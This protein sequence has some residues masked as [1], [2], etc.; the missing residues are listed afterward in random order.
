LNEQAE[1]HLG[2]GLSL[3]HGHLIAS[4][5]ESNMALQKLIGSV[6]GHAPAHEAEAR[7]SVAIKRLAGPPLVLHAAPLVRSACDIFGP[8]RALL[9]IVDPGQHPQPSIAVLRQAYG[10]SPAEARLA[11]E[12]G[13]GR[14]LKEIAAGHG[15]SEGTVRAQLKAIFA[16]T[17]THRQAELVALINR[18][19]SPLLKG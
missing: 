8:A 2:S 9:M 6:V 1:R 15:V 11:A 18:L 7:S 17:D 4:H 12:I 10:L 5:R 19:I 3:V 14:D 16:K 13:K